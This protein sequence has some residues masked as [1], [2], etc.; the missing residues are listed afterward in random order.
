[1]RPSDRIKNNEIF[2]AKFNWH[3]GEAYDFR[4]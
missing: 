4:G 2:G 3:A 1:M